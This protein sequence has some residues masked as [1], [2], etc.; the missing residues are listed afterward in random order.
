[1]QL[2]I[3]RHGD[4]LMQAQTDA[5]RPLSDHGKAQV[6]KMVPHLEH[7]IPANVIASPYL[8]AQQT[9]RIVCDGLG[10]KGFEIQD[11][12]TPEGDPFAVLRLLE[13]RRD[14]SLLLVSHQ[15]LV[16][17]LLGLLVDGD[18]ASGYMMGTA[19]VAAMNM[20]YVGPGQAE[21][22]WLRHSS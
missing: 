6:A 5:E 1:M 16:G 11:T 22:A 10:L 14:D 8:R 19:S 20:S 2:Y 9:A 3:M 15:P 12:I 18:M 17:I 4:A 7:L 21:L 13:S